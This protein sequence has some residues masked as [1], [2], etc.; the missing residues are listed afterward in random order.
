MGRHD[1]AAASTLAATYAYDDLGNIT[2]K[3]DYGDPYVYGTRR[4]PMPGRPP[5]GHL[6]SKAAATGPFQYDDTQHLP[7]RPPPHDSTTTTGPSRWSWATDDHFRYAPDG[8]RTCSR[9]PIPPG[10]RTTTT[11]TSFTS[12]WTG[13]AV[14]RGAGYIG[15]AVVVYRSGSPAVRYRHLIGSARWRP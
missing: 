1:L 12:G 13:A 7:R 9:R 2:S 3:G 10:P 11:R 8:S 5:R 4:G 15:P 6:I 14:V